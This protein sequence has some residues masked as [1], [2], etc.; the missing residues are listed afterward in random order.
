MTYAKPAALDPYYGGAPI[1]IT[2]FARLSL[3]D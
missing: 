3:G 1:G 2:L